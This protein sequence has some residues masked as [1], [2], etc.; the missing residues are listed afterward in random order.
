MKSR[1][2]VAQAVQAIGRPVFTSRE[3]AALRGSSVS[4]TSQALTGMERQGLLVSPARGLWCVPGDPRFTRFA[5]VPFLAGSHQAYVSFFSALHLHGV[6]EQIPQIVYAATTGHTRVSKTPLG[7]F[8]FHRID[9]L[10]FAGFDWYRGG[11][12]FLIASAEKALADCL[13]LSSKRGKQFRFFPEMDLD[14]P[15]SFLRTA[16]W[17]R[18]IPDK[19]IRTYAL[20]RLELMRERYRSPR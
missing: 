3:I 9:P 17:V 20:G 18:R 15:F 14:R 13:Y 5:L 4:A 6:V 11:R 10:I 2:S 7:S 8:S 19:R 16:D 12:D 1:L